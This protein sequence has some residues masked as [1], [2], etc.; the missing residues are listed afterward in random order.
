MSL[1]GVDKLKVAE[2][3]QLEKEGYGGNYVSFLSEYYRDKFFVRLVICPLCLSFWLGNIAAISLG[4]RENYA[5]APAVLLFY[6]I[7]N[8][9]L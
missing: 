6:L 4:I 9:L 8:K 2:Y 1:L 7:F 3:K 5:M